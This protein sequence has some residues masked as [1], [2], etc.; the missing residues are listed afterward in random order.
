MKNIFKLLLIML[1]LITF[2]SD[3]IADAPFSVPSYATL[4]VSPNSVLDKINNDYSK[5]VPKWGTSIQAYAVHLF[6]YLVLIDF[7]WTTIVWVKDR[8]EVG[9]ILTGY[10]GKI[11]SIGFFWLLLQSA[12]DWIPAI[13]SSFAKI[14]QDASGM[15]GV[16]LTPDGIFAMSLTVVFD[17]YSAMSDLGVIDR[18]AVSFGVAIAA[19][20][21]V[22]G[23]AMIAGQLLVTLV[24]SYIAI[25]GGVILLGFGGSRWTTDMASSYLKFAVGTG[26][27][28]MLC[29]LVIGA[30]M[31]M[32]TMH[33]PPVDAA[34]NGIVKIYIVQSLAIA[35]EALIFVYL[36]FNIPGLAAAMMSGSPNMSMG[37]IAGAAITAAAGVAGGGGAM[38]ALGGATS[39]GGAA[40]GGAAVG[41]AAGGF[42]GSAA[43]SAANVMNGGGGGNGVQSPGSGLGATPSGGSGGATSGGSAAAGSAAADTA[44]VA[45]ANSPQ[46]GNS[47]SSASPTSTMSPGGIDLGTSPSA[48]KAAVPAAS[49]AASSSG[50]G[51]S[52][53]SASPAAAPASDIGG[54]SPSGSPTADSSSGAGN[55]ASASVAASDPQTQMM[56]SIQSSLAQMA[57]NGAPQAQAMHDKISSLQKFV[58]NDGASVQTSGISMGHTRD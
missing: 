30:G 11:V 19:L 58:P 33:F 36:A 45:S 12:G 38:K 15:G 41:G 26:M 22:V 3:A 31:T 1:T 55:A 21:I 10:I 57:N 8:K 16:A 53:P 46:S 48:A 32:F 56:Q 2:N 50:G 25:G 28:L 52:A 37:G 29:Y 7:T 4:P 34:A 44:T 35:G 20:C 47:G 49:K 23:F 54:G 17:M 51:S 9:E 24:E 6:W 40:A 18:I 39:G 43:G 14:G 5:L 13:I 42:A 27:K